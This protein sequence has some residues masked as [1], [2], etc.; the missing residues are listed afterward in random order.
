MKLSIL[1]ALL[2]AAPLAQA[3]I[4]PPTAEEYNRAIIGDSKGRPEGHRT[5]DYVENLPDPYKKFAEE[6]DPFEVLGE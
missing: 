4:K 6:A 5:V 3:T 1:K 2:L